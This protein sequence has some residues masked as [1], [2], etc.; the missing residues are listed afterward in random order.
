[1]LE[2]ATIHKSE[3]IL[4]GDISLNAQRSWIVF[5][6]GTETHDSFGAG[7]GEP[8]IVGTNT[9]IGDDE[10]YS[11]GDWVCERQSQIADYRFFNGLVVVLMDYNATFNEDRSALCGS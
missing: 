9:Y 8:P 2:N 6:Q 3:E 7:G 5:T 1:L 10:D 4:T 11:L